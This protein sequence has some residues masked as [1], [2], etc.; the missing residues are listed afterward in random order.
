MK[1]APEIQLSDEERK[2]L[3]EMIRKGESSARKQTRARILLM[4]DAVRQRSGGTKRRKSNSNQTIAEDLMISARTVS[5]VRQRYLQEGMAA[6]LEEHARS[7]RPVEIDG[8]TEA[9][10]IA[11][12]CSDPPDGRRV[13]T[14]QLLA[15]RL[16]ELGYVE[17][18]SETWVR[19]R[20]KKTNCDRGKLRVGVSRK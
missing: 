16:I 12:A 15:D 8:E 7:G 2:I 13:W 11:L 10:L 18:V 19:K 1:V 5:R 20:L 3:R 17:K 6:A 4:A 9:Y 14:M